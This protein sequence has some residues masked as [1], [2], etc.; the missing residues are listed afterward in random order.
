MDSGWHMDEIDRMDMIGYIRLRAWK[1][2]RGQKKNEPKKAY[3]DEVWPM[4][5]REAVYR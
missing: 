4:T 5:E 1:A 3:I 2:R